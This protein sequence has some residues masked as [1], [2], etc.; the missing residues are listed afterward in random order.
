[1]IKKKRWTN[2]NWLYWL[3]IFNLKELFEITKKYSIGSYFIDVVL[4][5]DRLERHVNGHKTMDH[6]QKA[7]GDSVVFIRS[8]NESAE[9]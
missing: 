5:I 9:S 6:M 3:N 1:M 7:I 2:Y 4:N 8:L